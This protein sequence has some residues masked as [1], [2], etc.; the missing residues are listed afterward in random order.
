MIQKN[1]NSLG[2][3]GTQIRNRI[4]G[5]NSHKRTH[6]ETRLI[7]KIQLINEYVKCPDNFFQSI[8]S[9]V[10]PVRKEMAQQC[11]VFD[12]NFQNSCQFNSVPLYCILL[13]V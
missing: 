12:G 7:F 9:V 5:A 4:Y 3:R 11:N 2:L 10:S 13:A 1:K 8:R 6:L